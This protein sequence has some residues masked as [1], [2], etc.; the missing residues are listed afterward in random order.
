MCRVLI[1]EANGMFISEQADPARRI[2][3]KALVADHLRRK[4]GWCKEGLL[5]PA[6]RASIPN[7]CGRWSA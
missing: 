1:D 5:P 7:I 3:S 4:P 6:D 2:C